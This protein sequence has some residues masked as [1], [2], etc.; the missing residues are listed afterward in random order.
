MLLLIKNRMTTFSPSFLSIAFVPF[1]LEPL[2][3]LASGQSISKISKKRSSSVSFALDV[4]YYEGCTCRSVL[5]MGQ[6]KRLR[7]WC[8][9]E[10]GAR[11]VEGVVEQEISCYCTNQVREDREG[12]SGRLSRNYGASFRS[13]L[14]G[15]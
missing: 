4:G 1:S 7:S 10:D 8:R 13:V 14:S 2:E 3:L 6:K 15:S 12:Y 9:T 5:L 11:A